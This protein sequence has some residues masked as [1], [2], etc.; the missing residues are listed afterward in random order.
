MAGEF[1]AGAVFIGFKTATDG[2]ASGFAQAAKVVQGFGSTVGSV[3]K[4][5]EA[6]STTMSTSLSGVLKVTETIGDG[7]SK[8]ET[9][10]NK[11]FI[12]L[13]DFARNVNNAGKQ[14]VAGGQQLNEGLEQGISRHEAKHAAHMAHL[15]GRILNLQL[16]LATLNSKG[17]EDAGHFGHTIESVEKGLAT[18]ALT[19]SLLPTPAGIAIGVIAGMAVAFRGLFGQTEAQAKSIE[20]LKAK[21][22]ELS[23]ALDALF[24]KQQRAADIET[25]NETAPLGFGVGKSSEQEQ[26]DKNLQERADALEKIL[27]LR[28][29]LAALNQRQNQLAAELNK[30]QESSVA[31]INILGRNPETIKSEI[32]KVADEQH[33]L[34]G[35]IGETREKFE[36]ATE[37]ANKF[38]STLDTAN[39]RDT[40][41]KSVKDQLGTIDLQLKDNKDALEKGLVDPLEASNTEATLL[42]QKAKLII[43]FQN[44]ISQLPPELRKNIPTIP[45]ATQQALAAKQANLAKQMV[46]AQ[47]QGFAGAIGRAVS[48]GILSGAKAMEILANIGRNLFENMINQ[49]VQQLQT[50]L[51]AVF[52]AVAGEGGAVLGGVVT[53]ILGVVG[54]I[55]SKKS[56]IAGQS[57]KAAENLI[58]SSQAVRGIVAG[59]QNVAIAAVGDNL[60][61]ALVGTELRLDVIIQLL[62]KKSSGTAAATAPDVAIA[63]TVAQ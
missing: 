30:A 3:A 47:A 28:E 51:V 60:K 33:D 37:S 57:F 45:D 22:E 13:K 43:D 15:V 27:T 54:G 36:K 58:E 6:G 61:R 18:F 26:Q 29:K 48:D 49:A 17:G 35:E 50:G 39:K 16:A 19:V 44:Q 14:A 24:K 5:V 10:F 1:N 62:Q 34:N 12:L 32:K 53:G 20:K 55:L 40:L 63:G 31:G 4:Q 8:M 11:Q 56:G 7:T 21:I 42:L 23:G 41:I 46:E 2:L 25:L 38:A 52:K 9:A 59:P